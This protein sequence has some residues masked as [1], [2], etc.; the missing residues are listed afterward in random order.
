[1]LTN[2]EELKEYFSVSSVVYHPD[3]KWY[4]SIM[5]TNHLFLNRTV[6]QFTE[7]NLHLWLLGM[8]TKEFASNIYPGSIGTCWWFPPQ[9]GE[10]LFLTPMFSLL[11]NNAEH[12]PW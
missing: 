11:C 4:T 2:C 8:E 1:M 7:L 3:A 12:L 10:I 5:D 6:R 9:R